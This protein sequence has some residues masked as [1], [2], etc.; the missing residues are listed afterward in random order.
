[1]ILN[2]LILRLQK[3]R[4]KQIDAFGKDPVQAQNSIFKRLLSAGESTQYGKEYEFARIKSTEDYG[5]K[6]PLTDY[7]QLKPYILRMMAGEKNVL[8][9]T[10]VTWFAKSSGTTAG[11]SKFIPVSVECLQQCHYRGL[12]DV[13]LT[14]IRNYPDSKL[15]SGKSLTLGG[16]NELHESRSGTRFGD[17]SAVM[18]QNT[19][20]YV[21]PVRVPSRKIAL[22]PDFEEKVNA[23]AEQAVKKNV[24]GFA[25]TPAWNLVLMKKVLE[26]SGKND[27]SEVWPNLEVFFHGGVSFKPY[28]EQYKRLIPSSEMRYMETYNASEGFFALQDNPLSDDLLLM[29]DVGIFYEF[30]PVSEQG[31]A[32]PETKTM[33]EAETDVNYAMI[34]STNAGLWR[35]LIGDTIKFTSL[36]PHK[37]KIT[38]RTTQYINVFGE[39]L[40]VDNAENALKNACSSTGA[41]VNEYTAAPVFMTTDANGAHEWLVEFETLPANV[42]KFADILDESLCSLNSDYEAKRKNNATLTR[43]KLTVLPR[44]TFYEWMKSKNKLGGQNKAPRLSNTREYVEQLLKIK[45]N[46]P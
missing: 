23:I 41:V 15:L 19:P 43:L 5:K 42:E 31:K 1:M 44:N 12:K 37:I 33:G 35:Y 13:T 25:G 26:R 4:L 24:V 30:M 16:S 40:I 11:K 3:D 45:D 17:L 21:E 2:K 32:F 8:W 46:L 14:Y 36:Y 38:G 34:I 22:I 39:E 18:I 27:L 29:P 20:F 9:N 28:V 10:P 7:R 6:V